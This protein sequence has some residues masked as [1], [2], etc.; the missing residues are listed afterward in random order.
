MEK[1]RVVHQD[2]DV[3]AFA[4]DPFEKRS[5][6]VIMCHVAR[7]CE[8]IAASRRHLSRDLMDRAGE[9][10]ASGR[11]LRA[12]DL[13]APDHVDRCATPPKHPRNTPADASTPPRDDDDLLRFL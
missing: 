9:L 1:R 8:A 12:F 2:I 11:M 7:N 10:G 6:L 13:A 3:S 4:R 5:N